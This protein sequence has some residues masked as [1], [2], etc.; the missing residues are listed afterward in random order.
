VPDRVIGAV[1]IGR[2]P[3]LATRRRSV[4]VSQ[5]C[6]TCANEHHPNLCCPFYRGIE[7]Y[8]NA[9]WDLSGDESGSTRSDYCFDKELKG[10]ARE[11]KRVCSERNTSDG[12]RQRP[13]A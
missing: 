4:R 1:L 13:L 3:R 2:C 12:V 7:H 10:E 9:F 8:R 6:D 11:A 5:R